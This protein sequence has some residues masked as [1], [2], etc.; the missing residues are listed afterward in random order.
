MDRTA[1]WRRRRTWSG[2]A[3]LVGM[4]SDRAR[5]VFSH[6]PPDALHG[7]RATI[8]AFGQAAVKMSIAHGAEADRGG[9]Q[10]NAGCISFD[11]SDEGLAFHSFASF[12]ICQTRSIGSCKI[13]FCHLTRDDRA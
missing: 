7:P 3:S 12:G 4:V 9:Q 6:V 2:R 13:D 10:P 11:L 1:V 8:S 5:L